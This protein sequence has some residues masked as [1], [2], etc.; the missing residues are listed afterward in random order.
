MKGV[1][2]ALLIVAPF[3]VVFFQ[4]GASEAATLRHVRIG[5]HETFTRIVFEFQGSVEF[6]SPLKRDA[7]GI[8]VVFLNT[9]TAL[10]KRIPCETTKDIESIQFFQKD[11]H[12]ATHIDVL[13]PHF[14]LKSFSLSGPER[15][16][17]DVCPKSP[18]K[19]QQPKEAK[20]ASEK[21]PESDI[22][23]VLYDEA[24]ALQREGGVGCAKKLYKSALKHSP[25]FVSAL[26]NLGVILIKERDFDAA[27]RVLQK[28]I[29][30]EADY[31]D[32]YYNL[33]CLNALQN[34][35]NS[36]ISFLRKAVSVD[37]EARSWARTDKD[38]ENLR[39]H[40]EFRRIIK[41]RTE[42]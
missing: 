14:E 12:L 40:S 22:A 25:D 16:V 19:A 35:V 36:G 30:I 26:N 9:S 2:R 5:T 37:N 38:L 17:L 33:A 10:P 28:A 4:I 27:R 42:T 41:G 8:S 18:L 7:K 39:L 32:P 11:S 20:L 31:A 1:R 23:A 29:R 6:D 34:H 3:F 13:M 24:L 15:I 21:R